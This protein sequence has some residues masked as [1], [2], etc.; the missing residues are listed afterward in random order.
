[1]GFVVWLAIT[2]CLAAAQSGCCGRRG[3]S[4]RG[5]WHFE[6]GPAMEVDCVECPAG[7]ATCT[8]TSATGAECLGGRGACLRRGGML[9]ANL[10]QRLTEE[11]YYDRPHF[12]PVPTQPAFMV[13]QDSVASGGAQ[14]TPAPSPAVP[15]APLP[16]PEPGVIV[17]EP[18]A[19]PAPMP[20]PVSPSPMPSNGTGWKP[21][22]S[23]PQS[24]GG[25][26]ASWV[27]KS[28]AVLGSASAAQARCSA[29]CAREQAIR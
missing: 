2:C 18:E 28:P 8:E 21:R 5:D 25:R 17:P 22:G 23:Y 6:C 4:L 20:T 14:P 1:M 27:F 29:G 7:S 11:R 13:P 19:V 16:Q 9:L 24:G 15:D 12:Q 3:I 26:N 10:G